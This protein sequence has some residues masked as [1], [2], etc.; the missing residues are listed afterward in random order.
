M[1]T[2]PKTIE[3]RAYQVG[4][5]DCFLVSFDYGGS[6]RRSILIDFGTTGLPGKKKP[7]THMPRVANQIK[8][9][10]GGKLTAV[11]ATHRHADHISGFAT[12]GKTGKSGVIIRDLRP[13]VVLQPWTEDPDA[14]T[15]A[16]R[17]TRDSSRSEKSFVAGLAAMHEIA[18]AVKTIASNP[19][20]WMSATLRKELSFLGE[21]NIANTVRGREPDRDGDG[22]GRARRVGTSRLGVG[23]RRA[24][25]RREGA[26]ARSA[27]SRADREDQE[28]AQP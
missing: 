4:F 7:S 16:K 20:A 27:E 19:P 8:A 6:D 2:T 13:K 18:Q 17:A 28:D 24:P 5:G 14:R 9:D 10:C 25:A 23:P 21:D 22:Q 26:R 3:I 11:V 1:A 12:D 15:N